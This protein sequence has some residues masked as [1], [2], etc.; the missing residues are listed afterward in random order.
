MNKKDLHDTKNEE[1]ASLIDEFEEYSERHY[2]SQYRISTKN[3]EEVKNLFIKIA[4][5]V[6]ES[7]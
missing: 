2:T 6:S 7:I 3:V 4:F 5:E 1:L